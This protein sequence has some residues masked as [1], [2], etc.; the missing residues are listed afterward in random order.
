[1]TT[2]SDLSDYCYAMHN[3]RYVLFTRLNHVVST[4]MAEGTELMRPQKRMLDEGVGC[5]SGGKD[6]T[7]PDNRR[8]NTRGVGTSSTHAQ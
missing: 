6:L 3:P 8:A 7:Q 5:G 2:F 4:D 1:M